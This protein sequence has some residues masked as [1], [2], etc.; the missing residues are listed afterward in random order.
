MLLRLYSEE[1]EKKE[2]RE[3]KRNKINEKGSGE[4]MV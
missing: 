4:G 3:K 2:K 1:R